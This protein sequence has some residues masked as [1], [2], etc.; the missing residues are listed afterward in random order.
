MGAVMNTNIR[1]MNVVEGNL[2]NHKQK[3]FLLTQVNA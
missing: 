1:H 2:W 3:P